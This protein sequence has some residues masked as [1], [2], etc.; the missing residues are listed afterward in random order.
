MILLPPGREE[1]SIAFVAC[2]LGGGAGSQ[3]LVRAQP[4]PDSGTGDVGRVILLAIWA[5]PKTSSSHAS[6]FLAQ[7]FEPTMKHERK[8][9]GLISDLLP[10]IK[11]STGA[12]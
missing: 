11:N 1:K 7:L 2:M 5:N 3:G 10:S 4:Y 9:C 8:P 6:E 12:L